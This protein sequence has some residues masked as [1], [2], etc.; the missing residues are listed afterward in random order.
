MSAFLVIDGGSSNIKGIICD[1]KGKILS[2]AES[3]LM[4]YYND[5]KVEYDAEK[6]LEAHLH[7]LSSLLSSWKGEIDSFS[8]TGQRS[9]F[10][11]MDENGKP[12]TPIL[13][14]QDG[15]ANSF[16]DKF[17][18][19][20]DEVNQI[21]G[22]YKTPYYSAAKASWLIENSKEISSRK[23]GKNIFFAPLPTYILFHI[24]K[25]SLFAIDPTFAQR[26]LLFDANSAM[27]SD[28]LCS[29][30]K[31]DREMLPKIISSFSLNPVEL[32]YNGRKL[33]LH[34]IVGDQQAAALPFLTKDYAVSNF[35]TGA[36]ILFP[37][38]NKFERLNGI[39]TSIAYS[40]N[41]N[42]SYMFE[43]T[44]NSCGTFL[45]WL[46]LKM[47]IKG[48]FHSISHMPYACSH[49]IFALPAIGGIGSPYWDYSTRTTF[50]GFTAQSDSNMLLKASLEG[51]V[52]LL[53]ESFEIMRKK[54][55]VSKIMVYGGLSSIDYIPA[56]LSDITGIKTVRPIQREATALGL[57][58]FCASSLGF[59]CSDWQLVEIE[60]EF[61]P[62]ATFKQSDEIKKKWKN[63]FNLTRSF[64][65]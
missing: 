62:S 51:I 9:S 4:P 32:R 57:A 28:K 41:K 23:P 35:G 50:S 6:L 14:W 59:N 10:L 55:E 8:I 13:S 17:D 54:K 65:K 16:L 40:S 34:S 31:I 1:E 12:L 46:E 39:L 44:V 38:G 24:S 36:F 20:N 63:F 11:F 3:S 49:G 47:G 48:D 56:F 61:M 19:S 15:R 37:S 52:F 18:I 43:G 42:I 7:V 64:S 22:L 5:D 29:I 30:F 33:P 2:S 27:W 26:T 21:T 58:F 45:K 25:G 53:N 60:K